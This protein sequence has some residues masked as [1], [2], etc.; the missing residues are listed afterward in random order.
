MAD[1]IRNVLGFDASQALEAL[2]LLDAGFQRYTQNLQANAEA[3]RAF[4]RDTGKNVSALVQVATRANQA[5]EAIARLNAVRNA[6]AGAA[7]QSFNPT[8]GTSFSDQLLNA[9][10]GL[11]TALSQTAT[12]ANAAGSAVTN[13]AK[14]AGKATDDARKRL[15]NYAVSWETLVRVVTTQV[16]V[17]ALNSIRTAV[18]DS[19]SG[20]V[21]FNQKLEEI[22]SIAD[23]LGNVRG[24]LR[25]LSNE[26]NSPLLDVAQA[27][28][29]ILSNGFETAA[30]SNHI[31][32]SSLKL[33]KLGISDVSQAADL[34]ATILNAYGKS[35]F[36]AEALSGK[37]FATV[38]EGRVNIAELTTAFG[39]VAPIAA[40][41]G[42]SEDEI[43]AAFAAI[44]IGGAKADEAATQIRAA[45][46]ALLKPSDAAKRSLRELGFETGEQAIQAF[47]LQGA[48]QQLISTT[49]GSN[50]S[51]A[52]LFPNVRALNGVLRLTG[53]GAD[54][55]VSSL[56]KIRETAS[57][58]FNRKFEL[59][60]DSDAE[61]VTKDLNKLKNFFTDDL[62]EQL[63]K[64][65]KGLLDL[66]G[67]V[68]TLISGFTRMAPAVAFAIPAFV[69]YQLVVSATT[70]LQKAQNVELSKTERILGGLGFA[71]QG[72]VAAYAAYQAG[73]V[74]GDVVTKQ[75]FAQND[76]LREEITQLTAHAGYEVDARV[77]LAKAEAD[78]T[79]KLLQ[80]TVANARKAYFAQTDAAREANQLL[81]ADDK[82]TFDKIIQARDK[83]AGDVRRAA[84]QADADVLE[85]RKTVADTIAQLDD[86][87]FNFE[88]KR[89]NDR[90]KAVEQQYR[91]EELAAEAARGLSTASREEDQDAARSAFSRAE[92]FARQALSQAESTGN[93]RLQVEAEETLEGILE[94]RIQA[95]TQFQQ[96]RAAEAKRLEKEAAAE[97]ARVTRLKTLAKDFTENASLFDSSGELLPQEQL[98]ANLAK[99]K[100]S[101]AEFGKEAFAGSDFG[102]SDLLDFENLKQRLNSAVTGQEVRSL[103]ASGSALD[104]LRAQIQDGLNQ[105][106]FVV[107][108]T[109]DPES[110]KGL[111]DKEALDRAGQEFQTQKQSFDQTQAD[112]GNLEKLDQQI[113]GQRDLI[114]RSRDEQVSATLEAFRYIQGA[115]DALFR[116]EAF[117]DADALVGD[118]KIATDA[119]RD[120]IKAL[121]NDASTT[122]D[123]IIELEQQLDAYAKSAPASAN[124][125]LEYAKREYEALVK[126]Q[127]LKDQKT[128]ATATGDI[129]AEV[130]AAQ[131][132]LKV[133]QDLLIPQQQSA[134]ADAASAVSTGQAATSASEM[135]SSLNPSVGAS[136]RIAEN[137]EKAAKAAIEAARASSRIGSG[138][139]AT[140]AQGGSIYKR[141]AQGGTAAA[142]TDTVPA[143]LTEGEFVV[144]AKTSRQFFSQLQAVNAGF[145]PS[146]QSSESS[147]SVG[148]TFNVG[149]IVV[150]G[151]SDPQATAREVMTMIRREQR[152]GTGK[153]GK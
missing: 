39:R 140:A 37:L 103:Q 94:R 58:V 83:Y 106:K 56:D 93:Y 99:A 117:F 153:L 101:L 73:L 134:A 10:Q 119:F 108:L 66:I 18:E 13:A 8:V 52:K 113:Q 35:A 36:E 128:E 124:I 132:R 144:N 50:T 152:R 79:F 28:Y 82:A 96:R 64:T 98:D 139:V 114:N 19:F 27:K 105:V 40:E 17:R 32:T 118:T 85:S 16:I 1:E 112:S 3:S 138:E 5:A 26:F 43:L 88:I 148:D 44:T 29:D 62:G 9:Q 22:G 38:D 57:E 75:I 54:A 97:E 71:I 104:S 142:G 76:A 110:Y 47:G 45:L 90:A 53:T 80:Q 133:Q 109:A 120:Q 126:I 23:N 149:D 122:W 49:D 89:L 150:N 24:E 111:S 130:K 2:N 67:G 11:N 147:S 12:N 20:F 115:S 121:G 87:R 30:E 31:L 25:S 48:L 70:T 95:E 6:S 7:G 107:S 77:N 146:I 55:F 74:V 59:R 4:N 125:G 46:T 51:I 21:E 92:A 33:S 63:V 15:N 41:I 34:L 136:A 60:V 91:A 129:D 81:L 127:N 84:Q 86:Q 65:T 123:Q 145:R 116:W 131:D 137:M 143:M 135:L 61:K 72:V 42:A 151:S 141:Y 78:E 14:N 100:Q 68:D 69:S 102:V